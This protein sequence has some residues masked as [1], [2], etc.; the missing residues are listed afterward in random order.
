MHEFAAP[1]SPG[2]A[3]GNGAVA[4]NPVAMTPA[5][6]TDD[7][8]ERILADFREWLREAPPPA[9][10]TPTETVDLAAVVRQFTALRQ[11]VNLQT[12]A[13]RS[14]LEQNAQTLE[15]LSEAIE[16]LQEGEVAEEPDDAVRPILKSLLDVRDAL[17]LA[18]KHVAKSRDTA[19]SPP[20]AVDLKLP[21]WAR[22]LGIEAMV[23]SAVAPLEEWSRRQGDGR[24]LVESLVV[25]YTMSIQRLDRVLE[26]HG[27]ERIACAGR[28]F[29][30]ETM[31]VV[32][33]VMDA[34]RSSSEVIEEVRP[35]YRYG[36]QPFRCAQV[37]VARPV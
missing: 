9:E 25:G 1:G 35:G 26:Q 12:R 19:A 3:G 18:Q 31:E 24:A 20:P 15:K 13:S 8:I 16:H 37:R 11:E 17:A 27:L 6:L 34:S 28:P 23:R 10:T 22:W 21:A 4:M 14:Q 36:G 29:D 33:V 32:D 2:E 7:A 30:P 5:P